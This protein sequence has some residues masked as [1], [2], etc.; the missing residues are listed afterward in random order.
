VT[1]SPA[2]ANCSPCLVRSLISSEPRTRT[3]LLEGAGGTPGST[4]R[5]IAMVSPA[6]KLAVGGDLLRWEDILSSATLLESSSGTL[7]GW[8]LLLD[9]AGVTPPDRPTRF[10]DHAWTEGPSLR[11]KS[12]RQWAPRRCRQPRWP[13]AN[14]V[15]R[16]ATSSQPDGLAARAQANAT[17]GSDPRTSRRREEAPAQGVAGWRAGGGCLLALNAAKD[18]FKPLEFT[19]DLIAA[20]CGRPF[21]LPTVRMRPKRIVLGLDRVPLG[22]STLLCSRWGVRRTKR[23]GA[24]LRLLPPLRSGRLV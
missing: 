17:T 2:S 5:D 11:P 12:N 8:R 1:R 13:A 6:D 15:D 14:E 22:A 9:I 4:G 19:H 16:G 10:V 24:I 21:M 7:I 20:R 23:I 18:G 3:V